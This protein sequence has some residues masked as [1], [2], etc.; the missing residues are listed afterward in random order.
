MKLYATVTS[1]RNSRPA[2]KGGDEYINISLAVG[3]KGIGI[4]ELYLYK[5][6][7]THSVD[8]DEW[9]LKFKRHLRHDWRIISQ[10]HIM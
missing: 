3:N 8:V 10:G 7:E 1:E 2:K 9:I 6:K 5:D 4:L